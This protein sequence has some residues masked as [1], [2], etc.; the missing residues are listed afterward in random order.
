MSSAK[1][2]ETTATNNIS[3]ENSSVAVNPITESLALTDLTASSFAS[4]LS[5]TFSTFNTHS[6]N[7]HTFNSSSSSP[8]NSST[9]T[10]SFPSL[11]PSSSPP[12]TTPPHWP[13]TAFVYTFIPSSTSPTNPLPFYPPTSFFNPSNTGKCKLR[14]NCKN[15][16]SLDGDGGIGRQCKTGNRNRPM[17]IHLLQLSS[18]FRLIMRYKVD[19]LLTKKNYES[20]KNKLNDMYSEK[21]FILIVFKNAAGGMSVAFLKIEENSCETDPSDCPPYAFESITELQMIICMENE[22]TNDELTNRYMKMI[23]CADDDCK[24]PFYR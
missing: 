4:S 20:Y 6:S 5:Q 17:K 2:M 1:L 21:D 10:P 15:H 22:F 16:T 11:F 9:F 13:Y 3:L 19:L 14:R 23:K 18:E 7:Y 8:P 12:P 24:Y